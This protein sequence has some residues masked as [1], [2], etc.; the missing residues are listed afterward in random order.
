MT[1]CFNIGAL[2][3]RTYRV[4]GVLN[5]RFIMRNPK[6]SIGIFLRL[7]HYSSRVRGIAGFEGLWVFTSKSQKPK[8]LSRCRP[9]LDKQGRPYPDTPKPKDH[10]APPLQEL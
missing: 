6:K 1:G 4:L 7:L 3:I 2:I 8:A 10:T 9:R 5:T